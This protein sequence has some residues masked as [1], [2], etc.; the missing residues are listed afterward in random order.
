[1]GARR[2]RVVAAVIAA[3]LAVA[4]C[5]TD[6]DSRVTLSLATVSSPPLQDAIR[7]YRTVA[8]DV[9]IDVSFQ[10]VD[11]YQAAVRTRIG[12][13]RPPDIIG[14]WP[15][16]GNAMAVHQIGPLGALVDLSDEPWA[17]ALP[18][19]A[20]PLM[21][22]KGRVEMWA[23]GSTVIGAIY[24]RATLRE[25]GVGVPRTWPELL[26]ACAKLKRA[27]VVPIA[28]GNQT[29]WVTQ[30][31]DYALAPSTAFA[32]QPDLA[33]E[34][35]AGRATFASSGWRETLNRYMELS[36]RGCYQ[37][38]PN[39][40]TIERQ[41]ALVARG[42]AAMAVTVAARMPFVEAAAPGAEL[43]IFPF[44]AADTAE[45]LLI[46]AGV[47]LGL[48]VSASS[49]HI[50]EAKRFLAFL[51][52]PETLR[53]F[54]QEGFVPLDLDPRSGLPAYLEPFLPYF[55]DRRTVPFMDQLWPNA[56]TQQAHFA[57]AQDLL[58][59]RETVDGAL[60]RLDR[61]YRER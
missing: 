15:G 32:A 54:N 36:E 23:P 61:A 52:R 3:G 10:S 37:P 57:A 14:V 5:G 12:G 50:A 27:G 51:A 34:M 56:D 39:G 55:K 40:T 8:P 26:A 19:E 1:M 11:A 7:A 31:I 44:P 2:A 30:L 18:A 45:G 48:G 24:N 46:P 22:T 59:G 17:R 41:E 33:Q 25:A 42:E 49:P 28:V 58:A 47:A 4:A 21:G 9:R 16:N 13:G 60:D 6:P 53:R 38:N 43:G 20:R 35:L 29:S